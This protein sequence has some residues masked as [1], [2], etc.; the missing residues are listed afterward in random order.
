[1]SSLRLYAIGPD[2]RVPVD[3]EWLEDDPSYVSDGVWALSAAAATK[4]LREVGSAPESP[5]G[6]SI[7]KV[8][9]DLPRLHREQIIVEAV[10]ADA[11]DA[12]GGLFGLR[13]FVRMFLAAHDALERYDPDNPLGAPERGEAP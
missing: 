11:G 13:Q 7:A 12:P 3:L 2:G 6:R 9:A 10:V 1:M 5:L 8:W 4:A